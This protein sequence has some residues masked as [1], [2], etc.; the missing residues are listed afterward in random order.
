[1]QHRE[2][3]LQK[4]NSVNQH[5]E[6]DATLAVLP[7]MVDVL[8]PGLTPDVYYDTVRRFAELHH[9]ERRSISLLIQ[10]RIIVVGE[11]FRRPVHKRTHVLLVDGVLAFARDADV[12]RVPAVAE[13]LRSVRCVVRYRLPVEDLVQLQQNA[14][15]AL[16]VSIV[17]L[18]RAFLSESVD[19][20]PTS[21]VSRSIAILQVFAVDQRLGF[22][23]L[24]FVLQQQRLD[25]VG[26]R[27]VT[28]G[29]AL[30]KPD[31]RCS[32]VGHWSESKRWQT[33]Q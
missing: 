17:A 32:V 26:K 19:N 10:I 1:M 16:V 12:A 13:I 3:R 25:V 9:D 30:D 29:L 21:L 31:H 4:K 8:R 2:A 20:E 22:L 15:L 6:M 23:H 33:L 5:L 11:S 27:L 28:E 7:V 14:R 18:P 24:V